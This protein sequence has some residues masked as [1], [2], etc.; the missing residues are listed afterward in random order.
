[1]IRSHRRRYHASLR[2]YRSYSRLRL[3]SI[4]A[5]PRDDVEEYAPLDFQ[6]KFVSDPLGMFFELMTR[7]DHAIAVNDD[8]WN[9]RRIK[10]IFNNAFFGL[11]HVS[12]RLMQ[13]STLDSV[14][15]I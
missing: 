2:I 3:E 4:L 13:I 5:N 6:I 8:P 15:P 9:V 11:S 7:D 12:F 1:M 10:P 14:S